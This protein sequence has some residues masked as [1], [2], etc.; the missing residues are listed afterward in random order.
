MI[1]KMMNN[2]DGEKQMIKQ[3]KTSMNGAIDTLMTL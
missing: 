2:E 3:M 1:M